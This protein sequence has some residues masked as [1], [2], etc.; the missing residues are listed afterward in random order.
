MH[1]Y[2]S[3]VTQLVATDVASVTRPEAVG[4]RGQ[5]ECPS[6][7]APIPFDEKGG[8]PHPHGLA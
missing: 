6:I 1:S 5:S 7:L 8:A 3:V 2:R 4:T